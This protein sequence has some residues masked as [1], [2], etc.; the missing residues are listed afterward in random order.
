MAILS[1][2]LDFIFATHSVS[3][4]QQHN[5]DVISAHAKALTEAILASTPECA[6]QSA[7]IRHV[8][9]AMMTAHAAII[10]DGAV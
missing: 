1:T 6:D 2:G 5:I 8:R 4:K 7:A 3:D 9:E 10:L